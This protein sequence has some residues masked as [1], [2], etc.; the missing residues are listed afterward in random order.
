[1]D[2]QEIEE[3]LD[4]LLVQSESDIETVFANRLKTILQQISV[5]FKKYGN[6]GDPSWTDINKYNR[7]Q[8]EMKVIAKELSKDYQQLVKEISKT[9]QT[10]YIEKYLMTAYLLQQTAG[11]DI[12]MGFTI[13]STEV[14]KEVIANPIEFLGLP[15]ILEQHRNDIIRRLNIE[16][17]Q[18]FQ[19]GEGYAVMAQRI[20]KAMGFSR[21]KAILVV[22]TESGR[23]RSIADEKVAEQASKYAKMDK[24]WLSSLDLRVRSSHRVLDGKKADNDGYFHY[25]SL[26]T[27]APRLWAGSNSASMNIN[28]RCSVLHVINGMLPEYRRGRNY[29]D[30]DYQKKLADRIEK[31]MADESMTY[32]QALKK[33]QKEL[34]PP[35]ATFE[36]VTY[37]EWKEKLAG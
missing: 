1:M 3:Q 10:Q 32:K 25:K 24:I 19:A 22:R 8:K 14:V 27:K 9:Q 26:K 23:V 16:I 6:G 2:Q 34:Q 13:P 31:Y 11:E 21:K 12:N 18:S 17:A 20:E 37:N 4:K 5:M 29:M 36:Y 30:P 28:C 7:F 35:S 33:A 15:S